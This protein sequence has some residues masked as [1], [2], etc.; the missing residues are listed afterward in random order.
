VT[1]E[2][3]ITV[4]I[5]PMTGSYANHG[6]LLAAAMDAG[7]A[8]ADR[9]QPTPC[10]F[11]TNVL[12]EIQS[13]GDPSGPCGMAAVSV[14]PDSDF[15]QYLVTEGHTV[16]D[17]QTIRLS[18]PGGPNTFDQ[19]YERHAAWAHAVVAVLITAGVDADARAWID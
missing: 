10:I 11:T 9:V 2:A 18:A 12:G 7:N 5:A 8:A 19:S 13:Y 4:T 6:E 15:Y 16:R 14:Y 1:I 17:D 3:D